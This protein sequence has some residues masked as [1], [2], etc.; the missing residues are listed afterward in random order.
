M[1]PLA[2]LA[3]RWPRLNALLDQAL[4]VSPAERAAWLE[5]LEGEPA[6]LKATLRRLLEAP[7][8]IDT[9]DF[10][11]TPR[12]SETAPPTAELR[13]GASIGPYRLVREL[14]HGGM[15]AVW[16]AE[17]S[18][19]QLKRSVALKLPHLTWGGGLGERLARERNILATLEHPNIARL[20]EAGVDALGRP[21]MAMEYV[22]GRSIDVYARERALDVPARLALLLQVC[23]AVAYAHS[24]L[25][26]HRDLKP[27][28]ILV[29]DDGQVRLLDFGIAKLVQGDSAEAT[30][31]TQ[32]AGRALT[33]DY[34]SPE[35]V[36]GEALSTA[37]DV[38][39]L[40]VVAYELLAGRRPY[41]L[42]RGS[43]AELEE[44]IVGADLPLASEATGST[45]TK[46]HLRGDLDA[47][48]NRALKKDIVERY[49]SVEALAEDIRRHQKQ[50]PVVAQ[51]DRPTYRLGKFLRRNRVQ[52]LAAAGVAGA[53][54]VG[55]VA[56]T[57][58]AERALAQ[59]ERADQVK[60]FV[61]SLFSDADTG[62]SGGHRSTTALDLLKRARERVHKMKD[63]DPGVASELLRTLGDSL[64]GLGELAE[65]QVVLEDALVLARNQYGEGHLLTAEARLALGELLV[66]RGAYKEADSHLEAAAKDLRALGRQR[67]L[68]NALRYLANLRSY[69]GRAADGVP[70]AEEAASL[71]D[72]LP[73]TDLRSRMLAQQTLSGALMAANRPGRVAPA[74]RA[75]DLARQIHGDRVTV[76]VLSARS[77]HALALTRDG[78]MVPA[79]AELKAI[80]PQQIELLGPRHAEVMRTHARIGAAALELGE[81]QAAAE[82]FAQAIDILRAG[83]LGGASNSQTGTLMLLRGTALLSARRWREAD[84]Q[85]GQSIDILEKHSNAAADLFRAHGAQVHAKVGLGDLGVVE[86]LVAR[87]VPRI[88]HA[89][90][91]NAA[92]V[93]LQVS[94][95][96]TAQGRHAEAL[97]FLQAAQPYF[98]EQARPAELPRFLAALGG[99]QLAAGRTAD[100]LVSLQS[101]SR[102]FQRVQPQLSPEH[103]DVL[104]STAAALLALSRPVEAVDVAARAAQRW[105]ALD[106]TNRSAG[107]AWLWLARAQRAAGQENR[108]AL[109]RAATILMGEG[110]ANDRMLLQQTQREH[111]A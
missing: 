47:I 10:L 35:Q 73:A 6:E 82:Q 1:K 91:R 98:A 22:Q 95:L 48:L 68:M 24:R 89:S 93:R 67:Q 42:K 20:Y 63:S 3:T 26:I 21:W 49:P 76:D 64:I 83:D 72:A 74:R 59:A 106:A 53:L 36:R 25:V 85:L 29:T 27:S 8:G 81:P 61:L 14:G 4:D 16:L 40:G 33:P 77:N 34:A 109:S 56:A 28:N 108:V 86:A 102:E 11:S 15:G 70:L 43:A 79:I 5:A 51:P 101:A 94:L 2:D 103:A 65:A 78:Q 92:L 52:V 99:A 100:A 30:A 62:A 75:Y 55:L 71:A 19:G 80:L 39:S 12:L 37:S 9:R 87:I 58:Q 46:K 96:R 110:L 97:Q 57:W 41:R 90:A 54:A 7:A 104:V 105:D 38:Y 50:E 44:A 23:G 32:A 107:L 111:G 17:R 45:A 84:E 88:E 60:R 18:D 31:L 66:E 13:E 69:Q